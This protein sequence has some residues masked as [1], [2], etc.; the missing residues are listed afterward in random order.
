VKYFDD[1]LNEDFYV[2]ERQKDIDKI[3]Q[4]LGGR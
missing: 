4:L 1:D 2:H 3:T